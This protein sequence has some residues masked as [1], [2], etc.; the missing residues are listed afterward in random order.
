MTTTEIAFRALTLATRH[1]LCNLSEFEGTDAEASIRKDL[2]EL[3]ELRAA[4]PP[5][6]HNYRYHILDDVL[7]CTTCGLTRSYPHDREQPKYP[8]A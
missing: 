5:C 2:L 7:T 4:M 8:I 1:A 6:G 3:E